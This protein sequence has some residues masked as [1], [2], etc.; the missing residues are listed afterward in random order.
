MSHTLTAP[1]ALRKEPKENADTLT[2]PVGT[3]ILV[4]IDERG[5]YFDMDEAR[6]IFLMLEDEKLAGWNTAEYL[7]P[8]IDAINSVPQ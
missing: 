2:L 8:V 5:V 1:L 4:C 6:W 3:V 7:A